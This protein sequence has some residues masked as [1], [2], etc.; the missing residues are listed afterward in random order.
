MAP[1]EPPAILEK[2]ASTSTGNAVGD[3]LARALNGMKALSKLA[4]DSDDEGGD[5]T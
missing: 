2:N 5:W 1:K 4:P 3:V